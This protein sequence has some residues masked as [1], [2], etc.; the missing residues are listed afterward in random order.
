M[1]AVAAR[2]SA[3]PAW[4][5]WQPELRDRTPTGLRAAA[6]RLAEEVDFHRFLQFEFDRQWQRLR[7]YCSERSVFLLGDLPM[8]VAY[9]GSDVWANQ[10]LFFLDAEGR[11]TVVA[12]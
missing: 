6:A 10:S 2:G 12:G 8:F 3:S 11:R 9:E 5:S 1:Q 7:R 4:S